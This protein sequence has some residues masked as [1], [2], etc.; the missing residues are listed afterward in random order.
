[1]LLEADLQ[2]MLLLQFMFERAWFE[3]SQSFVGI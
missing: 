1:M 3:I 2:M